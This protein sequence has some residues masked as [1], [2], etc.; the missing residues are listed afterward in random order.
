MKTANFMTSSCRY[1]RYYHSE[2]RRGGTCNQL[3]VPV[4]AQ[5]KAC[6]LAARPFGTVWD[7]LEDVVHLEHVYGLDSSHLAIEANQQVES[8]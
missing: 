5:W 4:Q 3:N 6:T 2:G 8:A 7:N 1:C